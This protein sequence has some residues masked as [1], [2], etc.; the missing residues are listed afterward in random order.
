[1]SKPASLTLGI[2]VEKRACASP[3]ASHSWRP[4]SVIVAAPPV[5]GWRH[6]VST[7]GRELYHAGTLVLDLHVRETE[8][9]KVALSADPSVVY[10]ILRSTIGEDAGA[11]HEVR[12]FKV[13]ASPYEA[14]T[15]LDTDDDIVEAVAMPSALVAWIQAFV[16]RHHVEAPFHK[17]ARV[18]HDDAADRFAPRPLVPPPRGRADGR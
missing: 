4:S 16:D 12:P 14:Q 3:W 2:V 13:T 6:M 1:M 11:T 8:D 17:R 18:P 7:D 5:A 10:V 9:Y 15:Y